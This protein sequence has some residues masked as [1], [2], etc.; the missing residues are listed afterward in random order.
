MKVEDTKV[1]LFSIRLTVA[2]EELLL[3]Y[4]VNT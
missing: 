4:V 3:H 2:E 1:S